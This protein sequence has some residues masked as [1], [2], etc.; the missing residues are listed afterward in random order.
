MQPAADRLAAAAIRRAHPRVVA[1][2]YARRLRRQ[3]ARCFGE[4]ERFTKHRQTVMGA[5]GVDLKPMLDKKP[6][7]KG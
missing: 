4:R 3:L 2:R 1:V 5:D 7:A 6:D